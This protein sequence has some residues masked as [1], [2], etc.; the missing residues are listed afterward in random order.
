LF[1]PSDLKVPPEI[2]R[3]GKQQQQQTVE[4]IFFQKEVK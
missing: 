1:S 2:S 4:R 3:I